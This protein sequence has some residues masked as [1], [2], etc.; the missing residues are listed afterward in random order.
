MISILEH[1][2]RY[3]VPVILDSDAHCEADVGNHAYLHAL[4]EEI[5]FP[6]ELVVNHSLEMTAAFLPSL[7]KLLAFGDHDHD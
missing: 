3:Q 1:C 5:C 2:L 4:L 7:Q 6:K